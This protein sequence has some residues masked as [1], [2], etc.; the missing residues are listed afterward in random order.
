MC[1]F[2]ENAFDSFWINHE[3]TRACFSYYINAFIGECKQRIFTECSHM[4]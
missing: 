4:H 1:K 2:L 3:S